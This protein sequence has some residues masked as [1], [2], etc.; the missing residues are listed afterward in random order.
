MM[1]FQAYL[2][3]IKA[4][5][6]K[7][8]DD[9]IALAKEKGLL[10]PG[11]KAGQIIA[12]LKEDFGLGH[13]HAMAIVNIFKQSV[14]PHESADERI[15][16]QFTGAQTAWFKPFDDLMEKLNRFG[17]DVKQTATD[18]YISLLRGTK[19]FGIVEVSAERMDI[20]IKLKGAEPTGRFKAA[21]S[22][23]AMVTHRV[24][25]T[26]PKQIDSELLGWLKQAYDKA[27]GGLV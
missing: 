27:K 5:T 22:W 8:P 12:W 17:P 20:G 3:T 24:Q 4:K 26:E 25:V 1:S 16:K 10:E 2:D 14:G 18:S 21:G 23:N 19:K 9:F 11:V 13:G 6:G 7:K 15:A